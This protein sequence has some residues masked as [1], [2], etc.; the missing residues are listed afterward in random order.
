MKR[1]VAAVLAV[2]LLVCFTTA[3]A[4]PG[5]PSDPLVSLNYIKNTY[6]PALLGEFKTLADNAVKALYD[7][8]A[9]KAQKKYDD[10]VIQLGGYE[11]YKFAGSF[12]PVSIPL[13]K[14]TELVTG[15]T[16]VLVSGSASL[17]VS[18]GTV[19]NISTG[20]EV[21]SGGVST[22]QR[23]FCAENTAAVF[24]ASA[25]AV[26]LVDGYYKTTGS[27]IVN[28]NKFKDVRAADWYY[29][30]VN[31]VTDNN[32]FTGTSATTFSPEAS[33]TRGMFVTVL[34][35][36]ANKPAI[37]SVSIFSDVTNTSDYYYHAVVW[38]NANKIVTGYDDGRF[39]PDDPITREQMAVIMYRY[40]AYAGQGTTAGSGTAFDQ[41]P[42][43]G[44]VSVFAT[45]AMKWAVASKLINGADGRLLP[46]NTATR[47][48]VAQII[49]NFS[50]NFA[51]L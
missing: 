37:S 1:I 22:N 18:K 12:T 36:L 8:A 24:T 15:S 40:A 28:Q 50:R 13:G 11:G 44:S 29:T 23:Y 16:F 20:T 49:M 6:Y 27:V 33:M 5:S 45:D 25:D 35:R 47:A 41:F 14:T 26:C 38:A 32:L 17:Q 48:Q 46:Q 34:Y 51:G 43:K 21:G 4:A 42:D 31:H 30:A 10:A 2:A 9:A 3:L 19:I 39:H 7:D